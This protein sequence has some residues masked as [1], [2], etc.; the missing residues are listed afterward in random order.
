MNIARHTDK[1]GSPRTFETIF[2]MRR[3]RAL[4]SLALLTVV[5]GPLARQVDSLVSPDAAIGAFP[6]AP[7]VIELGLSRITNPGQGGALLSGASPPTIPTE[8]E[9]IGAILP[10]ATDALIDEGHGLIGYGA[11]GDPASV[12]ESIV[13]AMEGDGWICVRLDGVQGGTFLREK[14]DVTWVL[15][16][17]TDNGF[18]TSVVAW[19]R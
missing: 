17:C 4:A 3:R 8:A 1:K 19:Y 12:F 14:G 13:S 16:T 18:G 11:Q 9:A 2:R 7:S 10:D 15:V 6:E 5:L